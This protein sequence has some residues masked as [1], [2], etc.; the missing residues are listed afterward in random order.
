MKSIRTNCPIGSF[1]KKSKD[2][3]FRIVLKL[4]YSNP[5]KDSKKT[6]ST[7]AWAASQQ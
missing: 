2:E 3:D 4:F 1:L 7:P 5:G 6:A